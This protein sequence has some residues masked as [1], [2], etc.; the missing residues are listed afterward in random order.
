MNLLP[1]AI[2][3]IEYPVSLFTAFMFHGQGTAV[4]FITRKLYTFSIPIGLKTE[5]SATTKSVIFALKQFFCRKKG[6]SVLMPRTIPRFCSADWCFWFPISSWKS[7][8]DYMSIVF[9]RPKLNLLPFKTIEQ[10]VADWP[11]IFT[12]NNPAR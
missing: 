8:K 2:S 12:F 6:K 3:R 10:L 7:T 11:M 1:L 5:P 4:S 9:L